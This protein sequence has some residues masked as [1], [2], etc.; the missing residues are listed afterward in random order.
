[1]EWNV[2]G[3]NEPGKVENLM[4]EM[5][6]LEVDICGISETHWKDS[7]DF[8][9][10]LPSNDKFRIIYSGG[11]KK[12]RG[13]AFILNQRTL[14]LVDSVI[15]V[16]DRIIAVR[17]NAKP[18]NIFIVQCYAPTLD[19]SD[20]EREEFYEE[21]RK[22]IQMKKFHEILIL[23]GDFNAKVGSQ[24][25]DD[26]VGPHGLG[27]LNSA[28]QDLINFCCENEL[29]ITNTWYE[30]K[31]SSRHTWTSPTGYTKNQIDYICVIPGMNRKN[32]AATLGLHPPVTQ[33]TKSITS[34]LANGLGIQLPT[35]KQD[36]T[37]IVEDQTTT[38]Y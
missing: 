30:Q 35:Q 27:T 26:I 5:K 21:I 18:V 33:K 6:N 19:K 17:I 3:L 29:F 1:M 12:S 11:L 28:G 24:R 16:S 20:E 10:E 13:V 9:S 32:L 2:Q 4:N 31:E 22:T 23:M 36:T 15:I 8:I 14:N 7:N 37:P 34:V 25:I 38:L